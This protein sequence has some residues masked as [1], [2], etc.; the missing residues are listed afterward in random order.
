VRSG[1]GGGVH[2]VLRDFMD[3]AGGRLDFVPIEMVEGDSAF[4]NGVSF[5]DGLRDVG[6]R[7]SGSL[8]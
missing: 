7:Q 6:F 4:A 5:F 8:E 3:A 1:L 2:A